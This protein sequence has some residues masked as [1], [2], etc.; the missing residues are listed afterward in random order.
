[1]RPLHFL[2]LILAASAVSAFS[3]GAGAQ[4]YPVRPIKFVSM[5]TGIADAV[6]R[7]VA[8]KMTESIGQAVVVEPQ[9]G[10]GGAIGADQVAKSSPDG[11]TLF[12]SYPDPLVLRSLMVKN[13]PYDTLRDFTPITMML[14]A[15]VVFAA[16]PSVPANN[17]RELID[18]A[19]SNPGKL[20]YGT[21]GI[22]TSFQMAGEALKQH[23]GINILHVPFKASPEGLAALLRGDISMIVGAL[24]TTLP[25][26]RSGKLKIISIVNDTRAA[27]LADMP[28][29]R[30]ILPAFASPPYWSGILGPANLPAPVLSRLHSESVRAMNDPDVRKR[31]TDASFTVVANSPEEFRKR[32]AAEITASAATAK[33]AGIQPE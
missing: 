12:V 11:Y 7:M 1:M 30:E 33:A 5:A 17:L 32:I 18:Y 19:K 23:A 22:G 15:L 9:P 21:N 4:A 28:S 27:P 10:A 20:S 3:Q 29:T 16:N 31:A 6:T 26:A 8:Q 2:R 13:V 14:E 25:L 24:G